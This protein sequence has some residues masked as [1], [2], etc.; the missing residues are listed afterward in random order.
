MDTFHQ[1]LGELLNTFSSL[2]F[3]ALEHVRTSALA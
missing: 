3:I 2:G 1:S